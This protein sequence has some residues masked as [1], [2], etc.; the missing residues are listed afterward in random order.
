MRLIRIAAVALAG[1]MWHVPTVQPN[2]CSLLT[3]AQVSAALGVTVTAN[4]SLAPQMCTWAPAGGP[5]IGGKSASLGVMSAQLFAN[6][7]AAPTLKPSPVA[8]LGD[9]AFFFSSGSGPATLD[10]KKGSSAF[11]VGVNGFPGEQNKQIAQTLAK[12]V[13]AKL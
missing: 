10:V 7:K 1:V 9:E 2:A 8:G 12:A 3:A 13:L 5:T 6:D 4:E 11:Q